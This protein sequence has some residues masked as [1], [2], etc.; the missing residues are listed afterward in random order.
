MANAQQDHRSSHLESYS[1]ELYLSDCACLVEHEPGLVVGGVIDEG[2]SAC[3]QVACGRRSG[4]AEGIDCDQPRRCTRSA[5]LITNPEDIGSR[6][7]VED[8]P[9]V[10]GGRRSKS[11]RSII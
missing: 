11:I 1:R 10:V 6:I 9:F 3:G 5:C 4:L 8:G 2:T 7:P